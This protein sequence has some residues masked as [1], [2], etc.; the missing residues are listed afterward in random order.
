MVVFAYFNGFP[1][2]RIVNVVLAAAVV[3]GGAQLPSG[4]HLCH[5]PES[6]AYLVTTV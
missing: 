3:G 6:L 2:V 4:H 1:T 5:N